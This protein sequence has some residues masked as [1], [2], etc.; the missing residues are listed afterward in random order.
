M[1]TDDLEIKRQIESDGNRIRVMTVHGAKG[2]ESP[3]VILPDTAKRIFTDKNEILFDSANTFWKPR[4]ESMPSLLSDLATQKRA[5]ELRERDRL[6]YVAMTRAEKWLIVAAAGDLG[7]DPPCWYDQVKAGLGYSGAV[8]HHFDLGKGLRFSHGD[9][10]E[11]E[12]TKKAAH[13]TERVK[14]PDWVLEFP[15][16]PVIPAAALNP[17]DLGGAKA[18]SGDMGLDKNA[19]KRRG[20]QIHLLL[21]KLPNMEACLWTKLAGPILEHESLTYDD[22][23]LDDII[24]EAVKVLQKPELSFLFGPDTFA[25]VSI[26]ALL[27]ERENRLMNG[28]IDRL[29]IA[30]D[31]IIIVDYKT[32][33][34]VPS[35]EDEVPE[36]LMRQMGAYASAITQMYPSQRV[37][38][39]ILWTSTGELLSLTYLKVINCLK[40]SSYA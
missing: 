34:H 37:R 3:I 33:R 23:N 39:Y 29:I 26:S 27:P 14:T 21:E 2:L 22:E 31:E 4:S 35:H 5:L 30:K 8:E 16:E 7:G 1:E 36:G 9:W 17:S 19:A 18:L 11:L 24:D 15:P 10:S 38:P 40:E 6:L 12:K 28:I 20:N 25:E 32:N 13:P